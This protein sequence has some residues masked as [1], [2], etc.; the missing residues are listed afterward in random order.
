M[1]QEPRRHLQIDPHEADVPALMQKVDYRLK[2]DFYPVLESD[3]YSPSGQYPREWTVVKNGVVCALKV[4]P[5]YPNSP[6]RVGEEGVVVDLAA[7]YPM[8]AYGDTRLTDEPGLAGVGLGADVGGYLQRTERPPRAAIGY[9]WDLGILTP[10][11][12]VADILAA[13]ENAGRPFFDLWSNPERAW[14]EMHAEFVQ[15]E[16]DVGGIYRLGPAPKSIAEIEF[17]MKVAAR[18][19]KV[20]EEIDLLNQLAEVH[21]ND[22]GL[23]GLGEPY[24][25]RLRELELIQSRPR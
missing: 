15:D 23:N 18:L 12:T 25:T 11:E 19:D 13:Y 21:I 6:H 2:R 20:S 22:H 8:A 14:H 17:H 24:E 3:G 5:S 9:E 7:T 10:D 4:T 1:R 16:R